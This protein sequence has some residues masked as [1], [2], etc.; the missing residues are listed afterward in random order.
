MKWHV[1]ILKCE[2]GSFYAGITNDLEK[3]FER[4][5][6]S[7]GGQYT[8]AHQPEKILYA[9]EF[10]DR[11]S[12][13]AREQQIKK[14]SRSKKMALIAKDFTLLRNLSRSND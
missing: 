12:A 1:Y 14:W 13:Y 7:R 3:R 2:D 4:H 9:E 11:V 10:E 6:L 5:R 8:A